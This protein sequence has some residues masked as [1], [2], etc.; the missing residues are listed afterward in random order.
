MNVLLD[1]LSRP[2]LRD[3]IGRLLGAAD[4]VAIA[5]AQVRLAAVDLTAA[6]TGHVRQ[7]RILLGRLDAGELTSLGTHADRMR[8]QLGGLLRFL[9]SGRVQ[10]RSAGMS[11]WLPDFSVYEGLPATNGDPDAVCIIGAHYFRV[12]PVAQGP[13]F[14][15]ALTDAAA[16]ARARRRFDELWEDA[17][18][19]H[20]AVV[21]AIEEILA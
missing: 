16:V 3:V 8:E 17:H 12:S 11:A 18:D 14:T 1:E 21:A 19:V 9:R 15:C 10:I 7:C 6:E 5:V 20:P 2:E 4:A 13:A